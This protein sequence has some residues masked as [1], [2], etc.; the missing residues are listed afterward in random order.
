MKGGRHL[1]LFRLRGERMNTLRHV[2]DHRPEKAKNNKIPAGMI[3]GNG[4]LS[5]ILD[6]ENDDLLIHISK[7]DFWKFAPGH[8][9]DGGIKTVGQFRLKNAGLE[10]YHV[11]LSMDEGLL[12]ASFGHAELEIFV[13]PYGIIYLELSSPDNE[14]FPFFSIEIPDTSGS[15]NF[16]Y[17]EKGLEWH[18]RKFD[19]KGVERETDVAVCCRR[20]PATRRDGVKTVRFA[21]SV[22]TNFDTPQYVS[23][24][25]ELALHADYERDK[26]ATE[27]KWKAF[28]S[29]SRVT[30]PDKTI[31]KHYNGSLYLLACCMG[32][33][34]FPPGLYGN[35]VTDDNFP[36]NGDY[37]MNYNYEA[38]FYPVFSANHPELADGY[39]Q[40]L[41][42]MID[43]GRDFAK[44]EDCKG[45]YFP[46]SF[47]PKAYDLYTMKG[48]KEH[49]ILFLGQKSN[50]AYTAVIPVMQW[51]ATYDKKIAREKL[52]PYIREV[53]AFWEDYLVKENGRYVIHNDAIHEV[54]Y[55]VGESFKP[56]KA[57]KAIEATNPLLSLGL[58]RMVFRCLI[59]MAQ[60]L[61]TEPEKI[62]VWQDILENL[63]DY[64]T[65]IKRGKR[66]FRYT[67]KGI[68]WVNTNSLCIQ[69]IYPASQI[70]LS[71][72]KKLL[73]IARNTYFM[74]D[75]RLDDNGSNSYLPC[76]ARL[77][78]SPDYLTEG[79][80]RNIEEYALPN[81]LFRRNGGGIEHLATV[82]ATINEMLLQ[83][84]EGVIRVFPCW[85]R[86]ENAS[87]ENLRADGAFLV[88]ASL[89]KGKI[90]S[91][92][93]T[94]L[95][96]RKCRVEIPDGVKINLKTKDGRKVK[97]KKT[98]GC[99]EF[100]TVPNEVYTFFG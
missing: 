30:I 46:V 50:A 79:L 45:I 62:P 12:N 14:A 84:F 23:R 43:K 29:C 26:A 4:D 33:S 52:Y 93:I 42:D 18:L 82:P 19:G 44:L 11:S 56:E 85:N 24:G 87:F 7:C 37:H 5:V 86:N 83:S 97:Y 47:G 76:G 8:G 32:N 17:A 53:G 40:P 51:Y 22:V 61:E 96:G 28:F 72:D 63:S 95:M 49:G 38:P 66:C 48:C 2:C 54:E 3:T 39:M 74:N 31:E 92:T 67:E 16:E 25:M 73:K 15:R 57:K 35:F 80:R 41:L 10:Q 81:M 36:W 71:S 64:P 1:S 69:H 75:R 58:V 9:S 27:K 99:I 59:D 91:L 89:Q 65:F 94:S 77:G 20:F 21:V 100:A 55:Y 13:A 34:Q 88:S 68:S 78:V 90:A 6:D 98:D 70:G 60:E